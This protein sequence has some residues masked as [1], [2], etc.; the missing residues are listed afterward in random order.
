[1]KNKELRKHAKEYAQWLLKAPYDAMLDTAHGMLVKDFKLEDVGFT[2][3]GKNYY[4]YD[5][6]IGIGRRVSKDYI[7][8][9]IADALQTHPEV[10]FKE[11]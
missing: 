1:M 8:E 6:V 4:T 11:K 2:R 3:I 9:I 5:P 7:L 10:F